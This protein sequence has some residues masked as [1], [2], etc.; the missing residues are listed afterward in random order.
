MLD[1]ARRQLR[2]II[3]RLAPDI[4]AGT[5]VI[6]LEPACASVFRDEL[7]NLFPADELARRL[8]GQVRLFGDFLAA[9]PWHPPRAAG[10]ALVHGH[11]HHKSV[12]GMAGDLALLGQL[13]IESTAPEAG[14]CGMAGSFGFHPQ[15]L[16]LSMKLGERALLP[17]VRGAD[18]D[19]V[20]IANGYSCREQ[21][22]HG[23][24]RRALH[25][26]EVARRA[27]GQ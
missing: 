25:I 12:F 26:A 11:C 24:S 5:P 4:R 15:H 23:T 3:D 19:T 17:A 18:P 2:Q 10:R 27:L 7:L 22:A 6:V 13:G 8:A 14:C 9:A 16:P 21:I 20:I 1:L